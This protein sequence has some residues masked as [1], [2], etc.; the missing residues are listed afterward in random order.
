MEARTARTMAVTALAALLLGRAP[1]PETLPPVSSSPPAAPA[2]AA[3]PAT[4]PD[5]EAALGRLSERC[6]GLDVDELERLARVIVEESRR[7]ELPVGLIL[8]V[9]EVESSYDPFA[10][11]PVG[12]MG[13]MQLLPSTG[14][15]VAREL[16]LPWAGP[17]TLFDPATNVRLGVTYLRE[18]RDRFGEMSVAL[19]AYNW[20]PGHIG[21]RLRR[22]APLPVR[23]ASRVLTVYG[24]VGSPTDS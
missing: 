3:A 13:L 12:A 4:D 8:A 10:V 11:S 20:G 16:R 1:G 2:R 23:Y 5:Y 17:Q 7:H 21:R 9:I 18:L 6:R 19:A 15:E 22:G 14:A 24:R